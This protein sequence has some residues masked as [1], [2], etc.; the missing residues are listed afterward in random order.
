MPDCLPDLL[1]TL[2]A[3]MGC[4]YQIDGLLRPEGPL[5]SCLNHNNVLGQLRHA[6]GGLEGVSFHA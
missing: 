1:N 2:L 4:T 3:H 5:I 6:G